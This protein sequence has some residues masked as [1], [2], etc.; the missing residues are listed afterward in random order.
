MSVYLRAATSLGRHQ[1]EAQLASRR[2]EKTHLGL[3][4]GLRSLLLLF[5][6]WQLLWPLRHAWVFHRPEHSTPHPQP[7]TEQ[8][9]PLLQVA[10]EGRA[11][12]Q[13]SQTVLKG[14]HTGYELVPELLQL[15][16]EGS[17]MQGWRKVLLLKQVS[18]P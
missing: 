1:A 11:G 5:V 7:G 10:W 9:L 13:T 18:G 15:W 4:S 6:Q 17:V 3:W 12:A 8:A 2:A 16:R 14:D